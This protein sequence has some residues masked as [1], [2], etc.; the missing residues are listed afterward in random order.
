MSLITHEAISL[1]NGKVYTEAQQAELDRICEAVENQF[2][3]FT[4]GRRFSED[5]P[6][7]HTEFISREN[8]DRIYPTIKPVS[9][10]S[11]SYLSDF[12][13][14]TYTVIDAADY[15]LRGEFIKFAYNLNGY[16]KVIYTGETIPADVKQAL[17]EWVMLI[18]G[19][20]GKDGKQTSSEAKGTAQNNYMIK[21]SL[22]VFIKQVIDN[23]TIYYV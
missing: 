18:Y 23:Y 7:E 14:E 22:P 8:V 12:G 10:V 20:K 5:A 6:T 4:N 21:D 9:I 19:A 1:Y 17:I 16:Y 3:L 13:A 2:K 15:M 11:V